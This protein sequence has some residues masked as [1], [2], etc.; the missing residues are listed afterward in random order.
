MYS[1]AWFST[2]EF[3]YFKFSICYNL[4]AVLDSIWFHY[5]AAWP[6]K[7]LKYMQ[8]YVMNIKA[9]IISYGKGLKKLLCPG[10]GIF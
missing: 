4:S 7:Y 6:V 3:N 10:I 1:K 9:T 8:F 2:G 5:Y